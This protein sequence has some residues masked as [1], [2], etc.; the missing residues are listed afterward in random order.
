M[1]CRMPAASARPV[2]KMN[3]M[4]AVAAFSRKVGQRRVA[5][6]GLVHVDIAQDQVGQVFAGLGDAFRAV[7][8]LDDFKALLLQRQPDHFPQ[9]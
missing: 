2:I 3:G 8:R 7:G 6:A 5:R 4:A 9:P 1:P